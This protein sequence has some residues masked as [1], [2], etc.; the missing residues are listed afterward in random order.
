MGTVVASF[1]VCAVRVNLPVAGVQCS[2]ASCLAASYVG[3]I[4]LPAG[5]IL[6]GTIA[7]VGRLADHQPA[8]RLVSI[9]LLLLAGSVRPDGCGQLH[10][11]FAGAGRL[12]ASSAWFHPAVAQPRCYARRGHDAHSAGPA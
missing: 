12:G 3:T 9:G 6:A 7:L 11:Q 10:D 8:H 5:F 1:T 4:L 2:G